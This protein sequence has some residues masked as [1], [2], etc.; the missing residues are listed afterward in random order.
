M[1]R[2]IKPPA[3]AVALLSLF[4]SESDFP[5]IEGDLREEFHQRAG[6]SGPVRARRW[7]WREMCRNLLVLM[8]RGRVIQVL[9]VSALCVVAFRLATPA[10][11]FGLRYRVSFLGRQEL[12]ILFTLA[13]GLALGVLTTWILRG[14]GPMLRVMFAAFYGLLLVRYTIYSW[15]HSYSLDGFFTGILNSLFYHSGVF[16]P[17]A[18][19]ILSFWLASVSAER[20]L[21]R[22][23]A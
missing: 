11:M 3:I 6:T 14:R 21:H 16:F 22:R 19:I 12:R 2:S 17:S 23:L 10:F 9:V 20:L 1:T 8:R 18:W 4:A 13:L 15:D 5:Q 7:Y